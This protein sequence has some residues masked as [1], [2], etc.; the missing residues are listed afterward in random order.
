MLFYSTRSCEQLD[1]FYLF[2]FA[3]L[4]NL[5][6]GKVSELFRSKVGDFLLA[7]LR[8][9]RPNLH[10]SSPPTLIP[11]VSI[12]FYGSAAPVFV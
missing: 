7:N 5:P 8:G 6:E 12:T 1:L 9:N 4:Q 3:K 10:W 2:P 11:C